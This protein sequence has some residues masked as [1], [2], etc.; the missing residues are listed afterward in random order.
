MALETK[1]VQKLSQNLLMTPQLQQAIKLL[2]LGR[3]EYK[4]AIEQEL[5][6]NPILEEIKED[7][8]YTTK[9]R[10]NSEEAVQ[11]NLFEE[12]TNNQPNAE[13]KIDWE[14]YLENFT[15]VRGSA[16]PK[17][18]HDQDDK[19]SLEAT[20]AQ[21]ESLTDY[22]ISQIRFHDLN[23]QDR[24]LAEYII[25]SLDKNGYLGSSYEELAEQCSCEISDI[26]RVAEVLMS[27]EPAGICARDLQEC[28]YVQLERIGKAQSLEGRIIL[29]HLDRLQK[30]KY[31][32]IAKIE[33]KNVE[34]VYEAITTIQRLDPRPG[35]VFSEDAIRYIIPDIY[36]HK[37]AGEYVINLNEDGLPKL[38]V[39]SYY[40]RLLKGDEK[41]GEQ[42]TYLQERLKAASWLIKSIHQR[43][44]TIYRVTESIV[45]FQR[46]FLDQGIS[47]LKPL[48]LKEIADDIGMHEST[49][50]RVTTNKYVHTP[51]GLFELKYFF[52]TGIK[53]ANGEVS[54]SSV[55][56]R[57]RAL[58]NEEENDS[59][60]SDQQLVDI[61]KKENIQIAR[62]TVAKY[63][64]SLNI[65][66]SSKRKKLF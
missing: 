13:P 65:P 29:H 60:I 54:S 36:V 34:E 25:G 14:D 22:L 7:E 24:V 19:P 37:V 33:K 11:Q 57:I 47:K 20:L 15:D 61:L 16:T 6:E 17:G 40:L 44:N 51:Q 2:Q 52:T 27:L 32:Q 28:L 21:T 49:V 41:G 30:R 58:I 10:E 63:R 46:E 59:P 26:K 5:L 66:S 62:R 39:S 45:K 4:E 55:K 50:S 38:R 64:E 1:L 56:E 43:Q 8:D 42:R 9:K 53:T 31:D 18:L 35:H 48:V 23:Q 3:L 12:E